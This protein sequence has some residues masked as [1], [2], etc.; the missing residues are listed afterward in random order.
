MK[1]MNSI[2][3]KTSTLRSPTIRH[4]V[5]A[6]PSEECS[7]SPVCHLLHYVDD[8]LLTRPTQEGVGEALSSGVGT[9]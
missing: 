2:P 3:A 5:V 1:K 7:L 4:R 9:M 8:I 6:Q